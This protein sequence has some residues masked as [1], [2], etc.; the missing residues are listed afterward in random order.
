MASR[1]CLKLLNTSDL[2]RYKGLV[3]VVLQPVYLLVIFL[4]SSVLS[5]PA[6]VRNTD[7]RVYYATGRVDLCV[8]VC[9]YSQVRAV[10]Q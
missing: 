10:E 5:R 2:L 4:E 6:P 3:V 8:S 1:Q 9:L 7:E